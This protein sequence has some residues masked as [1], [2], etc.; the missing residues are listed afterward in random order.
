MQF[1]KVY[2][3]IRWDAISM[4]GRDKN[5]LQALLELRQE[6]HNCQLSVHHNPI[7]FSKLMASEPIL[8]AWKSKWEP[9]GSSWHANAEKVDVPSS[10]IV[11]LEFD[12]CPL[13]LYLLMSKC[14]KT[15]RGTQRIVE[16]GLF[17]KIKGYLQSNMFGPAM[18]QTASNYLH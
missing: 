5:E 13:T 8:D 11:F 14:N 4:E 10:C 1:N 12:Y 7:S 17:I 9:L 15:W 3:A 18:L 2:N 6:V 16:Y